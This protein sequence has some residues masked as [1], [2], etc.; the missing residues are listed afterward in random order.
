[1]AVEVQGHSPLPSPWAW[2][3]ELGVF[4]QTAGPVSPTIR[5]QTLDDVGSFLQP[6]HNF[7]LSGEDESPLHQP[8]SYAASPS[9][10]TLVPPPARPQAQAQRLVI[11]LTRQP[12]GSETI[13]MFVEEAFDEMD[14]ALQRQQHPPS[15][16]PPHPHA[17]PHAPPHML[18]VAQLSAA[19]SAFQDLHA[20]PSQEEQAWLDQEYEMIMREPSDDDGGDSEE[21]EYVRRLLA[22]HPGVLLEDEARWLYQREHSFRHGGGG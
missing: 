9:N 15:A 6:M 20:R 4:A 14:E 8:S 12:S 18:P 22:L 3:D 2:R 5:G 1:M 21:D 11:P 10:A 7:R 17:P 16:P 19:S 13:E